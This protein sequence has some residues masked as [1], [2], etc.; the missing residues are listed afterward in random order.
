MR[1]GELEPLDPHE[2]FPEID[3]KGQPPPSKSHSIQPLH[4]SLPPVHQLRF[5]IQRHEGGIETG[6]QQ[7]SNHPPPAEIDRH[8]HEIG[9]YPGNADQEHGENSQQDCRNR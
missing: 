6:P 1:L 2:L 8:H 9:I 4:P 7:P 5:T 3:Y